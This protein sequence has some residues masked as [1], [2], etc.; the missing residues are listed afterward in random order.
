[1][2]NMKESIAASYWRAVL[3]LI[4]LVTAYKWDSGG[5][6]FFLPLYVVREALLRGSKM[7][8]IRAA[9]PSR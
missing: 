6:D 8:F 7:V 9:V 5:R 2:F 1:M 3:L 4:P